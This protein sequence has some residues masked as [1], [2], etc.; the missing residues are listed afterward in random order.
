MVEVNKSL[1]WV[2]FFFFVMKGECIKTG[3]IEAMVFWGKDV[4]INTS[5]F[6]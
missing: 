2:F 4:I 1:L 5:E 3:D 6:A